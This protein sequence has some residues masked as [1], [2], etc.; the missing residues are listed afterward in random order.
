MN[1]VV[2][3]GGGHAGRAVG[4]MCLE[5]NLSVLII[6]DHT[7]KPDI[8][9]GEWVR[10]RGVVSAKGLVAILD[11]ETGDEKRIVQAAAIVVAVGSVDLEKPSTRMLGIT[12]AGAEFSADGNSIL[13]DNRGRTRADGIYATGS[14][15]SSATPDIVQ[16]LADYC[17]ASLSE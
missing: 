6:D 4:V 3:I 8:W 7:D 2:I 5:L 11:P 1:D 9:N 15:A 17:A 14:C 16:D 10:G 13:T 12:K